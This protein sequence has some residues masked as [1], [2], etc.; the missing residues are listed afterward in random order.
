[1]VALVAGKEEAISGEKMTFA[2]PICGK[3]PPVQRQITR[4]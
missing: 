2:L 1:V 4:P 3:T